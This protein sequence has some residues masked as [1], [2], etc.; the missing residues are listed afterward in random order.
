MPHEQFNQEILPSPIETDSIVADF[1]GRLISL[2]PSERIRVAEQ[3]IPVLSEII[4]DAQTKLLAGAPDV[5]PMD[6]PKIRRRFLE[7]E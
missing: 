7:I 4:G 6:E 5:R 1:V 3:A 2:R